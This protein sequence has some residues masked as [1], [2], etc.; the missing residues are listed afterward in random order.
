METEE[1]VVKKQ[2][3]PIT[4][5]FTAILLVAILIAVGIHVNDH[6]INK[7]EP[8]V[9]ESSNVE[10]DY[11]GSFY[12]YYDKGG[13]LFQTSVSSIEENSNY[14]HAD[15]YSTGSRLNVD[16]SKSDFLAGFQNAL[17]GL[18]VGDTVRVAIPAAEGY[19]SPVNYCILN[20][21]VKTVMWSET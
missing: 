10:V 11:S 14:V 7:M 16:M 5:V 19:H 15:S 20:K 6:V 2:R 13:A 18:N 21:T 17:L 3:E 9:T 1:V 8:A 4:M 12:D